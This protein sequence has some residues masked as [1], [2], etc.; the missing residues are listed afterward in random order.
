MKKKKSL[1]L[2]LAITLF[3]WFVPASWLGLD[4][5]TVLQQRT[6]SVFI[7]AALMWI[8]E[9]IPAW[10]TSVFTMAILL[11][12]V[13]DEAFILTPL[14][15]GGFAEGT[16]VPHPDLMASFGNPI[17]ILFLGGFILANCATKVGLDSDLA[18]GM[19]RIL[20]TRPAFVLL[21]FLLLNGLISMFMSNTA[22]AAM[23]FTFMIPVLSR[24]P[25]NER[26]RIALTLSIPIA[27]NLGGLGTPIG[28]PPNAIAIGQLSQMGIE[29]G[30]SSWMLHMVP[31]VLVMLL[32]S[33]VLLLMLYPFKTDCI[34][35]DF[36]EKKPHDRNY[37][38]VLFTL[39]LT[40]LLWV[41]EE[42]TGYDSNVVAML[43]FAIFAVTGIFGKDDFM[44][45]DWAVLWMVAGGFALGTAFSHT[46]LGD[47][48]INAIPF[49][50]WSVWLVFIMAGFVIYAISTF[51]SNTSAANLLMPILALVGT[52][53]G[54]NLNALGGVSSMLLF[55]AVN[56]SLTMT[57]PISTPPNAIASSTGFVPTRDMLIVGLIIGV[58]GFVFAFSWIIAF[59]LK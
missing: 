18:R 46:G 29:V 40:I 7:F 31:Y 33:W 34:E 3:F 57:L 55:V 44:Q 5:M 19:L 16:A 54:D 25:K 48:F 49:K 51:I 59:P 14:A 12:T 58:I 56:A 2:V 35:V 23:M 32:V 1:I 42:W 10:A 9:V 43:P 15:G 36:G 22:T 37:W 21:G 53:M 17:I 41:T 28:T 39:F 30:F 50:S 6:L 47:M 4:S 24:M 52:A 45:I 13:S 26:G 20:G 8:F 11:L 27:A 38:I